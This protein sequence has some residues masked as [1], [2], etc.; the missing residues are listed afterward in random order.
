MRAIALEDQLEL[1]WNY[2]R[3]TLTQIQGTIYLIDSKYAL[4]LS[5]GNKQ[6]NT[7]RGIYFFINKLGG[8]RW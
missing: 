7:H 1:K 8:N 3:N 6:E 5:L 2:F 4:I